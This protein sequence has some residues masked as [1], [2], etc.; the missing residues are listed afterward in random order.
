MEEVK[1]LESDDGMTINVRGGQ[2]FQLRGSIASATSDAKALHEI[3]GLMSPFASKFCH[4]CLITKKDILQ[5][6]TCAGLLMRNRNKYDTAAERAN[7]KN[8][9]ASGVKFVSPLNDSAFFNVGENRVLDEMHDFTEG[10]VPF[11]FN[12]CIKYLMENHPEFEICA[13]TINTRINVFNFSYYDSANVPTP[14]FTD[15]ALLQA[16]NYK[17]QQKAAQNMC[18]ARMFPFLLRD[19][20][21]SNNQYYLIFI[22]ILGIMR[23][24][25]SRKYRASETFMLESMI[26]D[27]YY[28][29]PKCF[30]GVEP[31]NKWHH[32]IH[33]PK[34]LREHGPISETSCIRYEG[35]L[36][37]P[38]R[39]GKSTCNFVNF[40]KSTSEYCQL[41]ACSNRLNEAIFDPK[42]VEFGPS[43]VLSESDR[44]LPELVDDKFKKTDWVNF[45]GDE[46]VPEAVVVVK[47]SSSKEMPLFAKIITLLIYDD[48]DIYLIVSL[49]ETICFDAHFNSW[50]VEDVFPQQR[51]LLE[52]GKI[53][54]C[55]PM[56]IL[57]SFEEES[58]QYVSP[59][60]NV[61]L[62]SIAFFMK[63][64]VFLK[65]KFL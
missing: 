42:Y 32:M 21:D 63:C 24:I 28:S 40:T 61:Q 30:P 55:G 16:G 12:L 35:Y 13:D 22:E 3:F 27:I 65:V 59:R 53:S 58:P 4:C 54:D 19:L 37:I 29:F 14:K 11:L 23:F 9:P 64:H 47:E 26:E 62:C 44:I 38:K 34:M 31:I 6:P 2:P 48:K 17:T 46:Y 18:L 1:L 7:G 51:Q 8:D 56:W 20:I 49:L 57:R 33:Y 41:V 43:K 39:L 5:Q 60:F 10:V 50:E 25:E 15:D 36:N 52:I 45:R